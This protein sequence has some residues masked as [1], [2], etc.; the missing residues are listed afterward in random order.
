MREEERVLIHLCCSIR[1]PDEIPVFLKKK[2]GLF[3]FYFKEEEE[4]NINSPVDVHYGLI[5]T[6]ISSNNTHTHACMHTSE[7]ELA[8]AQ[9]QPPQSAGTT[10]HHF[11][12]SILS[13]HC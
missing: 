9:M 4:K 11:V 13:A 2:K 5:A 6:R 8:H 3:A 1:F 7:G 10:K 12:I